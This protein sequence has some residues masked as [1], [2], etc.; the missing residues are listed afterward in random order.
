MRDHPAVRH[1]FLST[2][3]LGRPVTVDGVGAYADFSLNWY[4]DAD[5][6]MAAV[7]TEGGHVDG[8]V[9]VCTDEAAYERDQR[10]EALRYLWRLSGLA[11][12]GRLRGTAWQFH[13]LRL[14][15]GWQLYNAGPI[16]PADAHIHLNLLPGAR[17]AHA[18]RQLV[19]AADAFVDAAGHRAWYAQINSPVG[20]RAT[21]LERL[22]AEVIDRSPN[23]TLTAVVGADIERLTILRRL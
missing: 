13:R 6:G 8:Y 14:K 15:D 17:A 22:G 19:D 21:A 11:M 4:L 2:L 18:G 23:H 9:L 10:I 3:A 12:R 20:K 5:G 1:V 16:R 7:H